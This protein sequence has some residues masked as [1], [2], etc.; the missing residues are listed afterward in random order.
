MQQDALYKDYLSKRIIESCVECRVVA[1]IATWLQFGHLG[2]GG[3]IWD[4]L[5]NQSRLFY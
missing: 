2:N 1:Q 3:E 4:R 5:V